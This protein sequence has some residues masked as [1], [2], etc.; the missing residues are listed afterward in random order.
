MK[1]RVFL[2]LAG[3]LLCAS[4]IAWGQEPA[5]RPK[6]EA[7]VSAR[8]EL[9]SLI[10]RLAEN[11][12]YNQPLSKS[13]YSDEADAHFG[14][15]RDH[16][17]VKLAREL[18]AK[19]GVS[20]DAVMS[21]AVHLED[22]KDLKMRIPLESSP[23]RLDK[24]W[25]PDETREF[26]EKAR[27][28]VKDTDF[29]EFCQQHRRLYE[30]AA[31]RMTKTLGERDYVGWFDKFFGQRPGAKLYVIVGLLNG[32]CNY[33]SGIE[34]PD[35]REEICPVIGADKFDDE[36]LPV[37]GG[38]NAPTIAHEFCHSYTNPLVDKHAEK[39]RPAGERIFKGCESAMREQ[40]YGD[41][42]T[43]MR[44]SLVRA[45]VVR[46][47]RETEGEKAA[48]AESQDDQRRGFLWVGKLSEV[49]SE[50]ESQRERYATFDAFMPRVAEF[51]DGYA[52]EYEDLMA[53]APKVVRMIPANG[54]T[55]VDPNLAEIKIF[56][57]H[58]MRDGSWSVVGG[59]PHFPE[60]PGKC[61]YDAERKVFTLPVRLKPGWSY[62]L[63]LNRGK[64]NSFRSEDG[65]ELQSVEV[66]FQTRPQQ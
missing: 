18:R 33:S 16:A 21:M 42:R 52:K 20:Y 61:S 57:D 9:M 64:F 6:L 3:T 50:Y 25:S 45:C 41:W 7:R 14:T 56:F 44:E 32:P 46:F 34:F 31:Q 11:P 53:R 35:G 17:A 1:L 62:Q 5:S 12:E 66:N 60:T 43:M 36:G 49:L 51:F 24:R 54:A 39:L 30:A 8:V 22:A 27:E 58:P 23:A 13:P 63:W 48:Q 28:F 65:V 38:G 47:L 19:N 4:L 59:G 55:D 26:L 10:F 2:T 29:G 37:F 40:A 15:F